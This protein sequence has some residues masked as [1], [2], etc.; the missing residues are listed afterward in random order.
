M[1][2]SCWTALGLTI[3]LVS[4]S[5]YAQGTRITSRRVAT[6]SNP[7]AIASAPSDPSRLY[8]ASRTGRVA[9]LRLP[10][11]ELVA[12][13]FAQIPDA[14]VGTNG[15]L[16]M[17]FHPN[18]ANNGIFY[19]SYD[20]SFG[21][22]IVRGHVSASTPDVADTTYTTVAT[23]RGPIGAGFGQHS[24]GWIGF[25]SDGYL[26]IPL[27]NA[28]NS[29]AGQNMTQLA[30]KVLR[31][32]VDGPDNV[33]GNA[34]DDG[35]PDDD[36]NAYTVPADNP[37]VGVAD[38]RPEIWA[39]GT[40]NPYR[41]SID[42][43]TGD[44]WWGEVGD[45]Y[46]EINRLPNNTPGRNMGH[47]NTEGVTCRGS[48]TFCANP[49]LLHAA[50][51][52]R[53][54][55]NEYFTGRSIM[56]GAV[57]RGCAIPELRGSYVF[58]DYFGTWLGS[59]RVENGAVTALTKRDSLLGTSTGG[60]GLT[61]FGVDA[62]GEVYYTLLARGEVWKIVPAVERDCNDNGTPDQCEGLPASKGDY[63]G[64]CGVTIED[65]VAFLTD[66]EAGNPD[67]DFDDGT[68]RGLYDGGVGIEDLL[69][70]LTLFEQ[71]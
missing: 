15:F 58:G 51:A 67:A 3:A 43:E 8:I 22:K 52:Y 21:I 34:D 2:T 44:L 5:A 32:D 16:G 68:G 1:K 49:A 48:A 18:F 69:R 7:I 56:G 26:Y 19:M 4:A 17:A 61:G 9:I 33:P 45:M 71:G 13:P 70:Y 11:E 14:S 63:N 66:F 42:P 12:T 55:G 10:S 57:Y 23:F 28:H 31:L 30:G 62:H 54:G 27:G 39:L 47:P 40:R 64:D 37:F 38:A 41:G 59:F 60:I 25:G 6:L 20:G 24:G 29:S 46:E 36:A 35:Q 50:F 53:T 65:L